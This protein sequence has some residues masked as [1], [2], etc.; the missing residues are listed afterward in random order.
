MFVV[1]HVIVLS[2]Q[3]I[4]EKKELVI[5]GGGYLQTLSIDP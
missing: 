4:G 2:K 3:G 5:G 1:T